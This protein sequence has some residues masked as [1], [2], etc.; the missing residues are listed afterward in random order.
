MKPTNEELNT[1]A[2]R[3]CGW[4]IGKVDRPYDWA[5][6]DPSGKLMGYED[7]PMQEYLF[8]RY[9]PDYC[10]RRDYL[11][12]IWDEITRRKLRTYFYFDCFSGEPLGD[13]SRMTAD[14]RAH[15]EAFVKACGEWK[16]EW[17]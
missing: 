1:L 4:K 13:W 11:P 14:P 17:E 7:E 9:A 2:A 12:E 8:T 3:L 5:L 15:V 10:N 6:F 16:K